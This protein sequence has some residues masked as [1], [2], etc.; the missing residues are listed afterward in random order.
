MVYRQNYC[1]TCRVPHCFSFLLYTAGAG[2]GVLRLSYHISLLMKAFYT[3]LPAL[4]GI[5]S[6]VTPAFGQTDAGAERGVTAAV[7]TAQSSYTRTFRAHPQLYNGPEYLDYAKPYHERTGHQFFASPEKQLGSVDYN[8]HH[9]EAVPLAYD[10]VLDQVVLSPPQS[11]FMLRLVNE[12]VD[13]FTVN[14]HRFVRLVADSLTHDALRTGYYEVL[15][16]GPTQLLA[17]RAKR[18]QERVA[19]P[20][21]NVEFTSI[22]KLFI[23]KAGHYYAIG[24]KSSVVRLLADRSK[25]VQQYLQEHKLKFGKKDREASAV[26]LVRFYAGLPRA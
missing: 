9:F 17:K 20:F 2:C 1:A 16:D 6:L 11:P 10:V 5:F 12:K 26:Q 13:A 25:E 4:L 24:S 7:E 19:Q 21:I 3:G 23:Q 8:G 15:A 22:D 14:G 18:L